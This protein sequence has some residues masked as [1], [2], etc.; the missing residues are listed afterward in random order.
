[1][2]ETKEDGR[3]KLWVIQRGLLCRREHPGLFT[4]GEYL[5]TVAIG[6]QAESV[7]AFLRRR[8]ND[9]AVAVLPRLVT[10]LMPNFGDLPMGEVWQDTVLPLPGIRPHEACRNVFTGE[11]FDLANR[12]GE[13][14][15]PLAEVFAHFPVALLVGEG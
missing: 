1:L 12:E 11:T 13:A 6:S 5:P 7:F 14:V 2:I 3:V 9:W 10:R 4:H 15:L 8:N